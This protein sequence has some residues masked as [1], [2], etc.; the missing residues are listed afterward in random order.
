[1]H[2]KDKEEKEDKQPKLSIETDNKLSFLKRIKVRWVITLVLILVAII[3]SVILIVSFRKT[4]NSNEKIVNTNKNYILYLK[5]GEVYYTKLSKIEPIQITRSL[6]GKE[7]IKEYDTM[8]GNS[9]GLGSRIVLSQD[10]KKIFYIDKYN[11]GEWGMP[12]YYRDMDK[13]EAEP[14]KIDS[15]VTYYYISEKADIVTYLKGEEGTLYQ[16]NLKEK[17]KIANDV[18]EFVVSDNGAKIIYTTEDDNIYLWNKDKDKEKIASEASLAHISSDLTNIYYIKDETLYIQKEGKEKVKIDTDV[19]RIIKNYAS[20]KFYYIRSEP[21]KANIYD[22]VADDKKAEDAIILAKGKPEYSSRFDSYSDYSDA[23]DKWSEANSRNKN[24]EMISKID[25]QIPNYVLYFYDG[26]ESKKI[27]EHYARSEESEKTPVIM[28]STYD[29]SKI[30]K[31]DISILWKE[32]YVRETV[33]SNINKKEV[34][35]IAINEKASELDTRKC[36]FR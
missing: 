6:I 9:F 35:N 5:D 33:W 18:E 4:Q 11:T 19:T 3:I 24:R 17:T 2:K 12:L 13:K 27:S 1:M 14:I 29:N 30:E 21:I 28:Y 7:N 8:I 34:W 36:I 32:D 31:K 26:K 22:Y 15:D 25:M 10:A 20:D 23:W 16:H